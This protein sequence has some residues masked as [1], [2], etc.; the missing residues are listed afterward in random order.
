M[1]V[2]RS[3]MTMNDDRR[4]KDDAFRLA[5]NGASQPDQLAWLDERLATH[6]SGLAAGLAISIGLAPRKL[7]KADLDLDETES[8]AR[9]EARR[10]FDP[11]GWAVDQ[12]ARML[13]VLVELRR[14]R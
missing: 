7:G 6:R 11:S 12:T 9:R 13:L 1:L 3:T 5:G 14:R 10:G 8:A 2:P 4:A